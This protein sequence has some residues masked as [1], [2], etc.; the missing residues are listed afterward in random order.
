MVDLLGSFAM[1]VCQILS[2][3]KLNA[4]FNDKITKFLFQNQIIQHFFFFM[5]VFFAIFAAYLNVLIEKSAILL[6]FYT[7]FINEVL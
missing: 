1:L 5:L 2:T 6:W 7:Y 4:N 3:L